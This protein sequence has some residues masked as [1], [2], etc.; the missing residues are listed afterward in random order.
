MST[1]QRKKI[2]YWFFLFFGIG[3][4][5]VFTYE[6]IIDKVVFWEWL[7][8]CSAFSVFIFKPTVFL[9]V[10]DIIKNKMK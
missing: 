9:D 2:A 4:T 10:F 1:E 3:G 7:A 8:I 6:L 5:I